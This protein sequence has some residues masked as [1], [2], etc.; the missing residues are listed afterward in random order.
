MHSLHAPRR[1][2]DHRIREHICRTRNPN[3]FPELQI[4]RS[5][6][7]SW[8]RHGVFVIHR[9]RRRILHFNATYHPTAQWVIQQLREAFPFETAPRHLIFDRDS[10]FCP[11]VLEFVKACG[12][13]QNPVAE[14]WIGSLRRE[15]LDH[16][17]VL[18]EQHLRRLV[19][20]YIRHHHED[21]CHLGLG[22][23]TPGRRP[24]TPRPAPQAKVVA[25]PR[26]GG[27]HHRYVW[28]EAT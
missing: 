24:V 16:V 11:A 1:A 2:Y 25:L 8:L 13:W 21:R 14:R 9:D 6:T 4:P 3:L 19:N 15:L 28:R 17:V 26:V 20:S 7:I 5:T 12:P 27:L 23:D 22:R 18:G 10:I